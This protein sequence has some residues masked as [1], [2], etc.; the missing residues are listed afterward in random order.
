MELAGGDLTEEE[1]EP[2]TSFVADE[3]IRRGLMEHK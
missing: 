2:G 3:A 1:K